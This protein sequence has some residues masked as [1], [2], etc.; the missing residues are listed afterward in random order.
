[1]VKELDE[2]REK[3]I[4]R[5]VGAGLGTRAMLVQAYD[6]SLKDWLVKGSGTLDRDS[7]LFRSTMEHLLAVRKAE[8]RA[9][10]EGQSRPELDLID[11]SKKVVEA[12]RK[13]E[14]VA[15]VQGEGVREG[16]HEQAG[17][18]G[19]EYPGWLPGFGSV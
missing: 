19:G 4:S 2:V 11:L 13:I 9:E 14:G 8:K 16:D 18:S 1:M 10:E 5:A 17:E 15:R 12:V 7:F 6:L 3:I